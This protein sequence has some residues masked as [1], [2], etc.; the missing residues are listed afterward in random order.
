MSSKTVTTSRISTNNKLITIIT[1]IRYVLITFNTHFIVSKNSTQK[2][3]KSV[4]PLPH[5]RF[6]LLLVIVLHLC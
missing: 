3:K 1:I 6:L 4:P 5:I 2:Q